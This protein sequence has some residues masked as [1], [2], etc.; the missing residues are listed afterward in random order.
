LFLVLDNLNPNA[1]LLNADGTTALLAPLGSPFVRVSLGEDAVLRPHE[2]RAVKLQFLD[3]SN[4][5]I[6]YNAR[7]L[8][9]TPAP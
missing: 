6:S 5:A 4:S 9:I 8:D 7:V 1:T 3:T 2:T